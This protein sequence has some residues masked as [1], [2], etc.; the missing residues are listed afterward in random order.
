MIDTRLADG[1]WVPKSNTVHYV[2][3]FLK[4]HTVHGEASRTYSDYHKFQA[5]STIQ[6]TDKLEEW[7]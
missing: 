6:F 4:L 5:D 2:A 3:R 1:A 7:H